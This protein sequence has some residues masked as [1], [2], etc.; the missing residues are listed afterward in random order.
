MNIRTWQEQGLITMDALACAWTILAR[1]RR[2]LHSV[3]AKR[4]RV[5][6]RG[7]AINRQCSVPSLFRDVNGKQCD[8]DELDKRWST[9]KNALKG[10]NALDGT[11]WR[12]PNLGAVVQHYGI[13]TPW[14]DVVDN[15]YTA[16]WFAI[17]EFESRGILRVAVPSKQDWVGFRFTW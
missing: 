4:R 8:D 16:I 12:R 17:H 13:R 14:L 2:L 3:V 11:R 1:W 6:L 7:S 5:F 15:L 9:Y 10:L